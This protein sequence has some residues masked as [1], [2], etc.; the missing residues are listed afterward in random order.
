ML[1]K[2]GP[3]ERRGIGAMAIQHVT[4]WVSN[5]AQ[6]RKFYSEILGLMEVPRPDWFDFQGT[7]YA[8]GD[9]QIHLTHANPL[10]PRT[11]EH[12]CLQVADLELARKYLES[13]SVPCR[14]DREYRGVRRFI[15]FDPDNNYI[16]IAEINQAWPTQ[17][18]QPMPAG[19]RGPLLS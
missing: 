12:L 7:W 8:V 15:I 16:E 4:L 13:R 17:W 14:P 5:V 2:S 9:Q 18:P 1:E 10:P 6:S 19:M 3:V 11:T